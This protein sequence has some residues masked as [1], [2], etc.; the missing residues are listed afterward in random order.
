VGRRDPAEVAAAA[1]RGGADA[2]QLRDKAASAR[3]LIERAQRLLTVTRAGGVPLL[4]N[5]RVDVAVAAGADG[6]HVGQDDLPVWAARPLLGP[7]RIVGKS[8][9]SL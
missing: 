4:I 1:I 2:I 6:V 3:Q 8:T 7:E 9:H 5:D